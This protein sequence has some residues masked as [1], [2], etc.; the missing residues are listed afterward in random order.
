MWGE[1]N[2]WPISCA[3]GTLQWQLFAAAWRATV[4]H[5]KVSEQV[6][7]LF[8]RELPSLSNFFKTAIAINAIPDTFKHDLK[9]GSRA[10]MQNAEVLLSGS[11]MFAR[12]LHNL[13]STVPCCTDVDGL[14]FLPKKAF[15]SFCTWM[16]LPTVR[17]TPSC[18]APKMKM[19][20]RELKVV[21]GDEGEHTVDQERGVEM[22]H[23]KPARSRPKMQTLLHDLASL[24]WSGC[25][26]NG[27][28]MGKA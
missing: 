19:G 8:I 10:Q 26:S 18:V 5:H 28:F 2:C 1:K 23:V 14:V 13:H 12:R 6:G 24:D 15:N 16:L 17:Y 3:K 20:E 21:G 25:E 9:K 11:R 27:N 7:G 4:C 22:Y